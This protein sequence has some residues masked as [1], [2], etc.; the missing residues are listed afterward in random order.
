MPLPEKLAPQLATL[1]AGPPADPEQWTFETK[2][3]GYR[4]MARVESGAARLF[5]RNGHD[6]TSKMPEL[7]RELGALP[8]QAAWLDGEVVIL[9]HNGLP[10]FQAL[11]NAFDGRTS[12]I[13]VFFAF[14]MPFCNGSDLRGVANEQRREALSRVLQSAG[15]GRHRFS[16]GLDARP[17]ELLATACKLGFEGLIGKRK[18]GLYVSRRSDDWIKLKCTRRQEFVIGGFSDPQGSRK[19]LGSLILGARERRLPQLRLQR[20]LRV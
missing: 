8:V 10:D 1:V 12:K 11:Q 18:S 14:D 9:D 17:Q 2:F 13:M 16:E 5:T 7:A 3:D 19:G 6:W 15:G 20:G 4:I